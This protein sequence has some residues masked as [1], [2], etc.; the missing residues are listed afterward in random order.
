MATEDTRPSA[1]SDCSPMPNSA[2]T[3]YSD[4]HSARVGVGSQQQ[5]LATITGAEDS[6]VT[7]SVGCEGSSCGTISADGL[8]T[9]PEKIPNPATISVTA[10]LKFFLIEQSDRRLDFI[11]RHKLWSQFVDEDNKGLRSC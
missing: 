6:A 5:F 10:T 1:P 11:V 8:Y 2:G 9:A 4:L 7:W 3:I